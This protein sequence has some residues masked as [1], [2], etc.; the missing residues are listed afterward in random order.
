MNNCFILLAAG[1]GDRF[2]RKTP[3]QFTFYRGKIMY[4]HS[5][6]KAIKSKMFKNIVLVIQKS[7]FKFVK[8]HKKVK[9]V[10]GGSHRHVSSK[11]ALNFVKKFN[12]RNVFIHDAARPNFTLK[13]LKNLN[14]NLKKFSTVVPYILPNDSIKYKTNKI[15][16]LEKKNLKLMQTPQCFNFKYIHKL[17]N[18]NKRK[19]EDECT[20]SIENNNEIKFIKGEEN[21]IKITYLKDI[22]LNE[23]NYGLGFDVHRL[24]KGNK[25]FLGGLMVKSKYGTLGHSDGD[26]V[27]HS[28]TD[29]ILGACGLNDIGQKFSN[30]NKKFKNIR[31]T[32][33]LK[34]VINEIN[35]KNFF[36]NNIDLNI[37]CETP[38]I[39]PIKRKIIKII[40][41]LCN[42]SE[43]KINIKGKTTEKLGIIGKE[44]AIA[45][46]S[47]VSVT[48]YV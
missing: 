8:K 36:I 2:K 24:K 22:K 3:K 9:I 4:E 39:S 32:I 33:L 18:N 21:N 16:N 28:I 46:E 47:I 23:I 43:E 45:C 44:K 1:S 12:P 40:S 25:L 5:I 41:K 11:N 34:E 17:S 10:I 31:S 20:L 37:I 30:K 35:S 19:I 7:H 42:I 38:K 14:R 27:L 48:K 6:D 29:A 15:Y 26:P 13:L